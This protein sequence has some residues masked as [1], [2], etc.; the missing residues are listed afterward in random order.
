MK[1]L[2]K[3]S[4]ACVPI[5][6]LFPI[7]IYC[8][9]GQ[10]VEVPDPAYA[11]SANVGWIALQPTPSSRILAEDTHL[12][13]YLYGANI[14][15]INL[16]ETP[17]DGESYSNAAESDFGINRDPIGNLSGYAY[18][19]NIGWVNFEWA[20]LNDPNRPRIDPDTHELLGYAYSG[21]IGW[22]QLGTAFPARF[23][24]G[25]TD[26]DSTPDDWER[27]HFG[28]LGIIGVGSDFDKDGQS[29]AAEAISGSD[30]RDA[31]SY[32]RIVEYT[33]TKSFLSVTIEFT[34]HPNRQYRIE[35]SDFSSEIWTDAGLGTFTPDQGE[36]TTR[37]IP[38][39]TET[40]EFLRVVVSDPN[41]L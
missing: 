38:L 29:D 13:G 2:P 10:A 18:S 32:F 39:S 26:G 14:G 41:T 3:F 31:S 34:T 7:Y 35:R 8:L 11:Y 36:T 28:E 22:I 9:N 40:A 33:F 5:V 17:T 12:A 6:A 20:A 15:W 23:H 1:S 19:G 16:G 24:K 21:N 37:T 25:D 30:P 4:R 27:E